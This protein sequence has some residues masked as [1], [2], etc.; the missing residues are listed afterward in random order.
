[1]L[2][3]ISQNEKT[4]AILFHSH[5]ESKQTKQNKNKLIDEENREKGDW[6]VAK[7]GEGSP[8]TW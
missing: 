6:R 4:N 2:S 7:R 3:E 8:I 1:M 5:V